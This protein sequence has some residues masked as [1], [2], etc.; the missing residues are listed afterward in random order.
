[1][2]KCSATLYVFFYASILLGFIVAIF[3][4]TSVVMACENNNEL[5]V[6]KICV[7]TFFFFLMFM[8]VHESICGVLWS[9]GNVLNLA[10]SKVN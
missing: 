8:G 5:S 1:M 4:F 3:A 9:V 6:G 7:A 10:N 2:K